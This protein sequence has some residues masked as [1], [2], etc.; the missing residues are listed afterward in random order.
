M[1]KEAKRDV[2][3]I[4]LISRRWCENNGRSVPLPSQMH[5]QGHSCS[6]QYFREISY[7]DLL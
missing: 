6:E 5:L 7:D 2:M 4:W 3:E 1:D